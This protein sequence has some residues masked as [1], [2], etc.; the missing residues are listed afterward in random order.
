MFN[1]RKIAHNTIIQIVGKAANVLIGVLAISYLTR[2]L[3]PAGFGQY[4]TVLTFLQILGIFLDFG[5]YI[6]LL[7]EISRPEADK[8]FIFSNV[9]TLRIVSGIIFFIIAPT[10]ALFFPYPGIVKWG[11]A[12]T[13]LAF[14]LNSLIQVYSAVFQKEM[15]MHK[16]VLAETV[17]KVLFLASISLFIYWKSNLLVILMANNINS[18]IFFIVLAISAK[19]YIQYRWTVDFKY[20]KKFLI[21]AWPIGLTTVLNLIYFKADTLILSIFQPDIHVGFYGVPYKILEVITVM[22][23]LILGLVLPIF[24]VYWIQGDVDNFKFSLQKVFDLF[25]ILTFPMI[26]IFI[27]E[28]RGIINFIAGAEYP[29]SIEIL[30]ILIW[31]TALI[32]FSSLFNY[33]I[34]AVEKQKKTIKYFLITALVS[35]IGYLIFIPRFSYYGAAYMTLIAELL[36]VLFSYYLLNKYSH[37]KINWQVFYKVSIISLLTYFILCILKL[38]FV[39]ESMIGIGI[40]FIFLILL[41]IIS[42]DLIKEVFSNNKH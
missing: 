11:I 10:I 37:W 3:S 30:Q 35:L 18:I 8:N 13:S 20:W 25:I 26:V 41:R 12:L 1:T 22:P 6:V 7:R 24:T 21:L 34:I 28:A 2:Y 33:G 14:F 29:A 5:L 15:K 16:V 39:V 9:L 38:N 23:H 42:K 27:A 32:F 19:K 17:A 4:T 31:P 36:I 40:Y